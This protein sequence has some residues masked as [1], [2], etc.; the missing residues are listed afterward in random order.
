MANAPV[1]TSEKCFRLSSKI[2]ALGVGINSRKGA[3]SIF[4]QLV[5]TTTELGAGVNAVDYLPVRTL[6]SEQS[7]ELVKCAQKVIYMLNLSLRNAL[8]MKD[9][10]SAALGLAIDIANDI[11]EMVQTYYAGFPASKVVMPQIPAESPEEPVQAADPDGFN[12]PY[13]GNI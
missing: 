11:N 12:A 5:E 1:T 7:I 10:T 2:L 6:R 3:Q 9:Q 8:F 4:S 13:E